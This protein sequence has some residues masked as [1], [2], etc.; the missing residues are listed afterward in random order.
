[1]AA[2]INT[3]ISSLNAQRNLTTS[4]SSLATS[5]QRLSSGLRIN[6]AKDDAAGLA[7]SQRMTSQ[8]NGLT[9]AAANAND[10]ISLAQTAEGALGQVGDSLQ[11]IRELAVQSA[12]ATNSSSD[13]AALQQ[14]VS[15]L[16][17]EISRIGDTTSFNGLKIL[18]GSYTNQQYQI[19]A[20]AGETI[21]VSIGDSRAAQ[22][23]ASTRTSG[24]GSAG[25][26]FTSADA[27]GLSIQGTAIVN[28]TNT[29]AGLID[30][31]NAKSSVTGVTAARATTNTITSGT[32]ATPAAG[33][34]LTVNGTDI[35]IGTGVTSA[36]LAVTEINKY[37]TQTGVTAS[38]DGNGVKFS[39]ANGAD[40][41][42]QAGSAGIATAFG[43]NANVTVTSQKYEAGITLSAKVG[44]TITA[45]GT[46]ATALNLLSTGSAAP[47]VDSVAKDYKVSTL[48]IS[49]VSGAND[50][51]AAVDAALTQVSSTRATLG[52]IQNRF[53]AVVA[54][55]STTSENLTASR[56]RI[57]DADFAAET[58]N[59][60]RGQILQQAGTAMLAQANSLPN[61]VL[62][63][64]RG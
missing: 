5:L 29:A 12:N 9:R 62:A 44:T 36:A 24:A 17:S 22:L 2:V 41:T 28:T 6:S 53:T 48:D 38:V 42:L 47:K 61:G 8:I 37:S 60:T 13:R 21:N 56:S 39:S 57:Q 34:V 63:L 16:V 59:M 49:T 50:A 30:A 4:Q 43:G 27:A 23:G 31:I 58:A 32:F 11:R 51:L 3:N 55:L 25:S 14:E 40:F 18:D 46:V 35:A 20:N 45:T 19:G 54:N 15:Q 10:G 26:T 52:A 64:L 7:I 33:G 1:M